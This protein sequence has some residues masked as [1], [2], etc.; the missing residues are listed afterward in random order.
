MS[1]EQPTDGPGRDLEAE[2]EEL[3]A[4]AQVAPA[5]VIASQAQ[6]QLLDLGRKR[7][8]A[9]PARSFAKGGPLPAHE[10]AMPAEQGGARET[11]AIDWEV[12]PDGGEDEAIDRA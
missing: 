10:F 8:T 12:T 5:R 6:D 7:R 11:Q 2:L 1:P 9:R 3:T 4:D